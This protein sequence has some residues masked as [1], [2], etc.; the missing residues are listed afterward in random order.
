MNSFV[1]FDALEVPLDEKNLVEASAGTGKTFSIAVM[2]LRLILEK[3]I[4]IKEILLVTFTNNAVAELDERIRLFLRS[5]Y[6]YA[7]TGKETSDVIKTIIDGQTAGIEKDAVLKKLNDSILFLD[8]TSVMT[9]HSFCHQTL[10]NLAFETGQL[11]ESEL[12]TNLDDV[13]SKQVQEFWRRNI[14]TLPVALLSVLRRAGFNQ[15]TITEV[16]RNYLSGKRY[17]AFDEMAE[18][19]LNKGKEFEE[20]ILKEKNFEAFKK[21]SIEEITAKLESQKERLR[22]TLSNDRHAIVLAQKIDDPESFISVV[23]EKRDKNYVDKYLPGDILEIIDQL[24]EEENLISE[25]GNDYAIKLYCTAL[26]EVLAGVSAYCDTKGIQSFDSLIKNLH[27]A[28]QGPNKEKIIHALKRQYRA[29]FIDEFQDTDKWQYDIFMDSFGRDV[30]L[31][32]IG[33]PKQSIYAFRQADINTYFKA[34]HDTDHLYSMNVN[35]RSSVAMIESM[36]EFFLPSP[37]FDFFHFQNVEN[38]IQYFEVFSPQRNTKGAL[39]NKDKQE[40]GISITIEKSKKSL[41]ENAAQRI[42]ELLTNESYRIVTPQGERKIVPGDI[43]VLVRGKEYG[44]EMKQFLTQHNIPSVFVADEK[45]METTEAKELYRLMNAIYDP[46][47]D[48]INAALV[49][50]FTGYQS[51]DTVS[52]DA[53]RIIE[54]FKGYKQTWESQSI[55]SCLAAFLSDFGIEDYLRDPTK[56]NGLRIITNLYQLMELLQ[57]T[58]YHQ[59]LKQA[60][61]LSWYKRAL[62]LDLMDQNESTIRLEN[63][64]DAVTIMTIHKSKGLQFNIV[65]A[66][67]MDFTLSN[68]RKMIS[69]YEN[70][71]YIT[72]PKDVL[73]KQQNEDFETQSEQE[74]RRLMYVAITRAVYKAFIFRNTYFKKS[75]LSEIIPLL[76]NKD[77]IDFARSDDAIGYNSGKVAKYPAQKNKKAVPAMLKNSFQLKD[78]HWRYMSYSGLAAKE[79]LVQQQPDTIIQNTVYT[80]YDEF[81][82]KKLRKGSITG[83]MVHL[84]FERI[85]FDNSSQHEYIIADAINRFATSSRELYQQWLPEFLEQVLYSKIETGSTTFQLSEIATTSRVSELEFDFSTVPCDTAQLS[86]VLKDAGLAIQMKSNEPLHGLMKGF[87][88][89]LFEHEGKYYILDWKTNFLGEHIEDYSGVN[90]KNAMEQLNYQLQFVIYSLALK[91]YLRSR[92][93]HFDYEMFGGVIYCFVRGMRKG[94]QSGVYFHR[95]EEATIFKIENLLAPAAS[96]HG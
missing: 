52:F 39:H 38:K 58:A 32:F 45:I 81:I 34:Y 40:K 10:S 49:N 72:I 80:E 95:P 60:E 21:K 48:N 76:E 47:A 26:Q 91:K 9:I 31:F 22:S 17:Y 93:G 56:S 14:V 92:L 42:L 36:N 35:F 70:N 1:E 78:P 82:F 7:N 51:Y 84:I 43:G 64:A 77:S 79:G 66:V 12:V 46:V 2:V 6:E 62:E 73:N 25:A 28:L 59:H 86:S 29:V 24:T 75:A 15:D 16:V 96:V 94:L 19:P 54:L 74:F 88:D 41:L 68:Q 57:K 85:D 3:D 23:K 20:L 13:I 89:L 63:D 8:E 71:E 30:I 18:Y 37:E 65:I 53:E 44:H 90:L 5:A 4:N 67:Q 55:Y 61:L 11:F 87:I 69:L 27:T 83:N 50:N 33:D